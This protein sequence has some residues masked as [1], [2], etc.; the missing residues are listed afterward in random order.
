MAFLKGIKFKN[1]KVV[2]DALVQDYDNIKVI[3]GGS[4]NEKY[5]AEV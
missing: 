2:T 1:I 3:Y 5:N 4:I